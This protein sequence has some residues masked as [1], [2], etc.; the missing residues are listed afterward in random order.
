MISTVD[1]TA[2]E[3]SE[4]LLRTVMKDGKRLEQTEPLEKARHRLSEQLARLPAR[5]RHLRHPAHYPVTVSHKLQALRD[6]EAL[7]RRSQQ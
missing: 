5:N 1:E 6:R 4:P 2:P 3:G 7:A